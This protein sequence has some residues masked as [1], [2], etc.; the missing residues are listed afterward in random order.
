MVKYKFIFTTYIF[1]LM[2]FCTMKPKYIVQNYQTLT[3]LLFVDEYF[4]K[5]Q[6]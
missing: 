4:F 1:V 6:R 2:A 5:I 3:C